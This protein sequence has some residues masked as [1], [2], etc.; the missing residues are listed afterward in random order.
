MTAEHLKPLLGHVHPVVRR[1][2]WTVRK[3]CDARGGVA[4]RESRS[5]DGFGQAGW[6]RVVARTIAQQFT[7]MAEG[8][9]HPFEYAGC[10]CGCGVGEGGG[11]WCVCVWGGRGGGEEGGGGHRQ[12]SG[13]VSW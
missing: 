2:C 11:W 7:P 9:T 4:D 6:R 8:A 1:G 12:L 13:I 5:D 10:G 3:R